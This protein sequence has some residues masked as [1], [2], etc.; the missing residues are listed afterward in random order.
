MPLYCW[1][2][3]VCNETTDVFHSIS[4]IDQQPDECAHCDSK[5]F[6]G[7]VVMRPDG[8]KGYILSDTGYGWPS[9]GFYS[10]P[11]WPEKK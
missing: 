4:N 6:D 11:Y 10:Q 2:C 7:R 9:H 1:K 3:S 8:V 5:A